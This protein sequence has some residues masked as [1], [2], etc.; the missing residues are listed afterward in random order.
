[1]ID[2]NDDEGWLSNN[3]RRRMVMLMEI[4]TIM[5]MEAMIIMTI[6]LMTVMM[7]IATIIMKVIMMTVIIYYQR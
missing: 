2:Y 1:M 3:S 4:M 6:M 5:V 7:A